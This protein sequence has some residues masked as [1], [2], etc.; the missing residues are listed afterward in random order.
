M[1]I[2]EQIAEEKNLAKEAV[3]KALESAFAAAYR[4]DFGTREQN[5]A[6]TIDPKTEKIRIFKVQAIV[7]NDTEIENP[8]AEISLKEAKKLDKKYKVGDEIREEVA[9]PK[10]YGR[11]AAQTA[12]Q[13]I[14]Q[15]IRE[16]EREMIIEAYKD[17]EGE[18]VSGVVQRIEGN[19]VMIDIG[20]TYGLLFPPERSANDT[21]RPGARMKVYILRVEDGD[22]EPHVTVSRAHPDMIKKLFEVEVPEI[23]AGTVELKG[24]AREAGVR[25]KIAVH[26]DEENIDPVGSLVGRHGVRVQAVMNEINDEKIDIILWDP[27]EKQYIINALSPAEIK[28]IKLNKKNKT[29]TVI[30]GDDQLSLAIGRNGQNVRL[31]SKLT[32]WILNI[33]K[34]GGEKVAA[35]E[36]ESKTEDAGEEKSVAPKKEKK[37]AADKDEDEKPPKESE[38]EK[39]EAPKPPEEGAEKVAEEDVDEQTEAHPEETQDAEDGPSDDKIEKDEETPDPEVKPE[40]GAEGEETTDDEDKKADEKDS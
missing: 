31:A 15:R 16:A 6:A 38:D 33:E 34:T 28:D 9:P 14:M 20:K 11:V 12:K 10:E 30:V 26:S 25:T 37:G 5:I 8:E 35:I 23:S 32:D 7:D 40:G 27:D 39:E 19:V 21:Y 1:K 18:I 2:V 3:L 24:V 4:K 22:R 13:V 36:P 17:R 29:A